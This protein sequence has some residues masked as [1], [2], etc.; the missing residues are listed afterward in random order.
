MRFLAFT[1]TFFLLTLFSTMTLATPYQVERRDIKLASQK[2]IEERS[3]SAPILADTDRI[4]ADQATSTSETEVTSFLAQPD[5]C[6]NITVTPGG[7]TTDVAAGNVT[8]T[9]TNVYGETITEDLAFAADASSATSGAKA[10]CTVTK[11]VFPAQDGTG[12]TFDVG[13]GDVLGLHRCMDAA[14][15]VLFATLGGTYET[16]R[17]TCV[18]D[19]DEVEKNTCDLNGTL[20]GSKDVEIFFIQ[21]Y[22][23]SP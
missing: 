18:A 2:V 21:N 10:F 13:V 17:P 3:L 23:C 9:G 1:L 14:G 6:R 8:V 12:A 4:L 11:V 16:T 20:D 15:H 5:V 7:T 22:R 19:V